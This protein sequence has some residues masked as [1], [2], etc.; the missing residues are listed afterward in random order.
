MTKF[1]L[2]NGSTI[3]VRF[4]EHLAGLHMS[5][6]YLFTLF[7]IEI[8]VYTLDNAQGVHY[9]TQRTLCIVVIIEFTVYTTDHIDLCVHYLSQRSLSTLLY[10]RDLCV[11]LLTDISDFSITLRSIFIKSSNQGISSW[12]YSQI[13]SN[14][15]STVMS[16]QSQHKLRQCVYT[17]LK[18]SHYKRIIA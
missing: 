8:Y 11:K 18:N 7:I 5:Q 15:D 9:L 4:F 12:T 2:K 14:A 3:A 13:I 17:Q 16:L 1:H 6:R 10:H